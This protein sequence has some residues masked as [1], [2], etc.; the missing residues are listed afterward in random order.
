MTI[1]QVLSAIDKSVA[2]LNRANVLEWRYPGKTP[3]NPLAARLRPSWN[4]FAT[5]PGPWKKNG[6]N[7]FWSEFTFPES[8]AGIPLSGTEAMLFIYGWMPFTLWFD[9]KQLFRENHAWMATGPIA[10]PLPVPIKPGAK[11]RLVLCVEPTELPGGGLSIH[12]EIRYRT[13]VEVAVDIGAVAAEIRLAEAVARTTSERSLIENALAALEIRALAKQQWSDFLLSAQ[14]LEQILHPLSDRVKRLTVHLIGHSHIDMDW[15]WTWKDTLHCIR[16]DLK[17]VTDMMDDFPDLT[18]THSQVSTYRAISESDPDVFAK[19]V[20]RIK[21]GRWENAAGT[22]VEGDLNMAD[23]ESIVRHMLYSADWTTRHMDS[24]ARV[25]WEPD[26]FGHPGN[27]PQI[28]QLGEFDCYFHWRCNPDKYDGWPVWRWVGIDGTP[29]TCVSQCYGSDLAPGTL[30]HR[31]IRHFREG[32]THA[33]HIWGMGDHGGALA[34]YQITLMRRFQH[35]P[36]IPSLRFSTMRDFLAAVQSQNPHL[37]SAKGQTY[38]LFEGC[39]TT[40]ASIK[41]ENRLCEGALLAAE[42][43]SALAGIN[44]N[45]DIREGWINTLFNHFHDIF[46]GAAVHDTYRNATARSQKALRIAKNVQSAALRRLVPSTSARFVTVVNALGF[47][48]TEPVSFRLPSDTAFLEDDTGRLIPIQKSHEGFVFVAR[49]VPAFSHR[50]YRVVRM[51]AASSGEQPVS[52]G[53]EGNYFRIETA[54]AASMLSKAG[55]I[56][57]SYFDKHLRREFVSYGIPI[58]LTHVPSTHAELALNVFQIADESHNAMT[59]WLINDIMRREYLVR[60]AEVHLVECGPVFARFKVRHSFRSSKIEEFIT[61]YAAINRVD[62]DIHVDWR[63]IG[64]EKVGV[65]QLKVSFAASIQAAR[66]RTEGPFSIREI[67]ADGIEMPTQKWADVTGDEAG[68]A[69]LND[70]KY[71]V[72]ILGSRIR[73]T[74]LRNPYS[75]DPETDN[76]RHRIRLAFL[77]HGPKATNADLVKHGMSFNRP[78]HAVEG[79]IR[80]SGR[81]QLRMDSTSDAVVCTALR[82]AEHS[83]RILLRLFNTSDRPVVSEVTLGRG[84]TAAS[85]V[86]FLENPVNGTL[87]IERGATKLRFRPFEIKTLLCDIRGWA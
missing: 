40:H 32:Q 47:E 43:L 19:I 4:K 60:G 17:A 34:R 1:S 57:G 15:M 79:G 23:G 46:D 62:F 35:R 83:N 22:W 58:P 77:P 78:L 8:H 73:V 70:S 64:H 10:D 28:A 81:D 6:K 7:W 69:V 49:N 59:A 45:K 76:G 12:V 21:E 54:H 51:R 71:G 55:G 11:H 27:M 65:P 16:R 18:F 42:T 75:P 74:L 86:N 80:R 24:K 85:E 20:K 41:R 87:K 67:P 63:E 25:L 30:A 26:T 33:I 82:Q 2:D 5:G 36:L 37:P 56:V 53:D 61:W 29:I 68:F 13:A 50:T 31:A 48:R 52:V 39:F 3:R 72:D 44:R 84:L 9:G 66:A 38:T 14:R